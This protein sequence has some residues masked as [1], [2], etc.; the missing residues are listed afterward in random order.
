MSQGGQRR[1]SSGPR[2]KQ[3]PEPC[4][5]GP[6]FRPADPLRQPA[7]R[8]HDHR[9]WSGGHGA[10]RDVVQSSV[11]STEWESNTHEMLLMTVIMTMMMKNTDS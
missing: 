7:H 3:S 8:H 1:G 2:E 5:R 4:P 9:V 6:L 11:S 10:H